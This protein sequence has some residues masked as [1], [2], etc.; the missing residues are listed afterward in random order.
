MPLQHE[1]RKLAFA[2]PRVCGISVAHLSFSS[3][4]LL[5]IHR[6][7]PKEW[8]HQTKKTRWLRNVTADKGALQSRSMTIINV[9]VEHLRLKRTSLNFLRKS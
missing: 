7:E 1:I 9:P 6:R 3:V 8:Q 4:S 2:L 5:G